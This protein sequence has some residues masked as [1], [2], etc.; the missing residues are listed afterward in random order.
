MRM[1]GARATKIMK[2]SVYPEKNSPM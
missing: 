2:I 1:K